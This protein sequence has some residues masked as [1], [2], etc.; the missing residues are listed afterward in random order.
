MGGDPAGPVVGS[1]LSPRVQGWT[2]EPTEK[3]SWHL[4]RSRQ[5]LMKRLFP[6]RYLPATATT[7]KRECSWRKKSLLSWVT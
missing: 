6:V 5:R 4:A 3:P 1:R 2:E 7:A